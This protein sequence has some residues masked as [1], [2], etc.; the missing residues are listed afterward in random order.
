MIFDRGKGQTSKYAHSGQRHIALPISQGPKN[1]KRGK[2]L[3]QHGASLLCGG[4][5]GGVALGL[6]GVD[7]GARVLEGQLGVQRTQ[8]RPHDGDLACQAHIS[9]ASLGL[10]GKM[11]V[12]TCPRKKTQQALKRQSM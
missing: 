5:V 1:G 10:F 8:R 12:L 2:E 9:A 11:M 4:V 3:T 7:G 6:L